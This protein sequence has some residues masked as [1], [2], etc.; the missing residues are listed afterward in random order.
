[1][2]DGEFSSHE[3]DRTLPGKTREGILILPHLHSGLEAAASEQRGGPGQGTH[4]CHTEPAVGQDELKVVLHRTG[5]RW[6]KQRSA[7]LAVGDVGEDGNEVGASLG[8]GQGG[9][10][11]L[12]PPFIVGIDERHPFASSGGDTPVSRGPMPPVWLPQ[13]ADTRVLPLQHPIRTAV[14]RPIVDDNHFEVADRLGRD[15]VQAA[16]DVGR[17]LKQGDNDG[18][19]Q[20]LEGEGRG[21]YQAAAIV[22][23]PFPD[24]RRMSSLVR[25]LEHALLARQPSMAQRSALALTRVLRPGVLETRQT[26]REHMSSLRV[27]VRAYN[28]DDLDQYRRLTYGDWWLRQGLVVALGQAGY[29]VTNCDPDV[30]IH[31]HGREVPLPRRAVKILWVH[32]NPDRLTPALLDRYDHVFCASESLATRLRGLGCPAVGLGLA[33][34]LSPRALPTRHQVVFVGNARPIGTRP[35][36]DALGAATFDLKIWGGRFRDLPAGVW[37]GEYVEYHDLPEVYG[38]SVI[39]LND[40]YPAMIESGIVSPRVYDILGSGGFCIS[41]ANPGLTEIFGD[42]VPQYHTPEELRSLVRYYLAN[43]LARLPLMAKGQAIAR[44][45][46]WTDRARALMDPVVEVLRQRGLRPRPHGHGA[47]S[48]GQGETDPRV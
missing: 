8:F 18:Y 47:A 5:G 15:G 23:S 33:T 40:H 34:A 21:C 29:L 46:S 43:P 6:A 45:H 12:W 2:V 9:L 1:M 22:P 11:E 13:H 44:L 32:D 17:L 7:G 41:D 19:A 14:S 31:L 4:G 48:A 39:S 20:G 38:A 35:V 26:L 10:Q 37:M 30:V 3:G 36:I 16:A 24:P 27:S 42:A 28:D 25:Y